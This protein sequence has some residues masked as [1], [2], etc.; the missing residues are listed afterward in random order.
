MLLHQ[1]TACSYLLLSPVPLRGAPQ[2]GQWIKNSPTKAG[3]AG[4]AGSIPG[5]GRSSGA[6]NGNPF[7][8]SGILAWRIPWTEEPGKQAIVHGVPKSWFHCID[9]NKV[10]NKSKTAIGFCVTI[11]FHFS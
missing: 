4:D 6:G 11:Q 1:S 5:S 10:V 3:D 7:W 8:Y 9:I 2:V